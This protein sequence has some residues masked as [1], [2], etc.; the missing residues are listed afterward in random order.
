MYTCEHIYTH[1]KIFALLGT[2][3]FQRTEFVS[4][5][6]KKGGKQQSVAV[7]PCLEWRLWVPISSAAAPPAAGQRWAGLGRG[8]G[9]CP[10]VERQ[11]VPE[12]LRTED[13]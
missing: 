9:A 8:G 11:P 12:L 2:E 10:D 3:S 4:E 13:G 7:L 1:I 6:H 5:T